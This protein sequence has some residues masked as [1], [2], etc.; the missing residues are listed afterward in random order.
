M[1]RFLRRHG[2]WYWKAGDKLATVN[3][4]DA[5]NMTV[6]RACFPAELVALVPNENVTFGKRVVEVQ[7]LADGVM[8][9][10]ADGGKAEASAAVGCD[11]VKSTLRIIVLSKDDRAAH[12]SFHG[13]VRV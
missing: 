4:G 6:H 9:H 13:E 5:G 3:A 8:L 10:F 7:E 12:P 1:V 2:L 11:G